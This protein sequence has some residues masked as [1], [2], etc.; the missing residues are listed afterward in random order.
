MPNII[1]GMTAESFIK[2]INTHAIDD[3]GGLKY[4]TAD[5]NGNYPEGAFPV[6]D[7]K[8]E[9]RMAMRD[10]NKVSLNLEMEMKQ[11]N[12]KDINVLRPLEEDIEECW[13][14]VDDNFN[15]S[16][17][18]LYK[19][20]YPFL[21][22]TPGLL[23]PQ[24]FNYNPI[25]SYKLIFDQSGSFSIELPY[26]VEKVKYIL[27]NGGI[28]GRLNGITSHPGVDNE[29]KYNVDVGEIIL[30]NKNLSVTVGAHAANHNSTINSQITTLSSTKRASVQTVYTITP[31]S[32]PVVTQNDFY[33]DYQLH[34]IVWFQ[35]LQP[36]MIEKYQAQAFNIKSPFKFEY[37]CYA[38]AT[39][40]S[41]YYCYIPYCTQDTTFSQPKEYGAWGACNYVCKNGRDDV[42]FSTHPSTGLSWRA[43]YNA[44]H[45]NTIGSNNTTPGN[46][47]AVILYF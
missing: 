16:G 38:R 10:N 42:I 33:V 24:E 32:L 8:G 19:R 3:R 27:I 6:I 11:A 17:G 2:D 7:E 13:V 36:N 21:K 26:W 1:N 23:L 37:F 14:I 41:G 12:I 34:N 31:Q 44:S 4:V 43:G 39:G 15:N 18:R 9:E 35:S 47:G 45:S 5:E 46:D 30:L 25:G 28:D 29:V 20:R 22:D 40:S